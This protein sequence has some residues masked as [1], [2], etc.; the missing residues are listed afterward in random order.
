MTTN[1][2][3]GTTR[4]IKLVVVGDGMTLSVLIL[5]QLFLLFLIFSFNRN[6]RKDLSIDKL[7]DRQISD[8]RIH[9]NSV[10]K[11]THN[12]FIMTK[13]K[14]YLKMIRCLLLNDFSIVFIA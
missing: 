12:L 6:G 2:N 10:W 13:T 3:F 4:P 14:G 8:R 7:Y 5:C 9:T 1:P 11:L